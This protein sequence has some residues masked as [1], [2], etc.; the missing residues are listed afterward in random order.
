MKKTDRMIALA[1]AMSLVVGCGRQDPPQQAAT[2][3]PSTSPAAAPAPALP[4]TPA[5]DVSALE[6]CEI[7]P[8]AEVAA[9]VGGTLL[10][11][12]PTGFA[13]CAYVLDANGTTESYRIAFGDPAPYVAMLDAQSEAERGERLD[14]LWDEAYVQTQAMADGFSVIVIRRGDLAVEATGPRKEPA[15]EIARLA[16]SRVN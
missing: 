8:P 5:R 4:A 2:A 14:G 1:I 10:N 6:A 9:I 15:V 3:A 13:N 7:V 12:P 11:E 16:V